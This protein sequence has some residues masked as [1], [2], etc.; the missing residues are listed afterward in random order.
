MLPVNPPQR[1]DACSQNDYSAD[2]ENDTK[3]GR[4]TAQTQTPKHI[5]DSPAE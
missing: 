3:G 4:L 5:T 1:Q 2:S